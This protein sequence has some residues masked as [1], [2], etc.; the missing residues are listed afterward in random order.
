LYRRVSNV[1]K[2]ASVYL[3]LYTTRRLLDFEKWLVFPSED[4]I[5]NNS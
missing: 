3:L 5:T 1:A 4:T 2:A